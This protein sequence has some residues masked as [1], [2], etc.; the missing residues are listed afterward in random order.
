MDYY[1]AIGST[2]R[3]SPYPDSADVF[4]SDEICPQW[5]WYW[6]YLV[7]GGVTYHRVTGRHND[8]IHNPDHIPVL[9]KA[10]TDALDHTRVAAHPSKEN[11]CS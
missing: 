11:C 5:K 8:L 2:Y 10:L 1:H 4:L 9:A 6:R 3:L 7:R